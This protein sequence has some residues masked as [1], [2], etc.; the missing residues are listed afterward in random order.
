M[1]Q[2]LGYV[3][4]AVVTIAV[5]HGYGKHMTV[6]DPQQ[7]GQA[8]MYI[9]AGFCPGLLS[10]VVPKLAVVA[11]LVR[12]MNP[13]AR[14]KCI[15]WGIAMG[16]G[17]LLMGCVLI[18]Y[19]QCQPSQSLWYPWIPGSRCWSMAILVNYSIAVGGMFMHFW[20]VYMYV[21]TMQPSRQ[22]LTHISPFIRR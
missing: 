20:W 16:S 3:Y 18:L 8:I 13:S 2:L 22:P 14:Q 10:I 5:H 21:L 15:L 9:V 19:V 11:L 17:L 4:A 7:M 6:L 12:T 1:G